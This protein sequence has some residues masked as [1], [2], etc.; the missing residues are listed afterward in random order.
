MECHIIDGKNLTELYSTAKDLKF[1]ITYEVELSDMPRSLCYK[2]S[3]MA[4][5]GVSLLGIH[6]LVYSSPTLNRNVLCH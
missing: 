2:T 4:P 3:K 5:T 1:M 6:A